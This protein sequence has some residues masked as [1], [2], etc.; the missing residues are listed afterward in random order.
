MTNATNKPKV[1]ISA[2]FLKSFSALPPGQQKKVREFVEKF[3]E[4]PMS[5]GINYEKI[6]QARDPNVRSVRIDQNYR[7]IVLKPETGNAFLLLWVE[8]HDA[9][10]AW[11]KNRIFN[12]HP[13]TGSLQVLDVTADVAIA[14]PV[15]SQAKGL[16]IGFRDKDLFKVG[17]PEILLPLVRS[18][19]T[20][21]Q[22][23][24]A[25]KH[26]PQESSEAL[27]MLASGFS[28][29]EVINERDRK[30]EAPPVDTTDFAAALAA[31]DS[32][33]RFHIVADAG[34]LNEMNAPLEQW[35]I[36]L[37]PSQ[38]KIVELN[39]GGPARVLGGAGTGKTV[40]AMHRA[41]WLAQNFAVG[42]HDRVLLTTF[43][44]NLAEDI[45]ENMR[46][47]CTVD[48]LKK[49][50]IIN[51]DGWV[52]QF[53]RKNGYE[54]KIVFDGAASP[55]WKSALNQAPAG[56]DDSRFLREEW[57]HV[58]QA[59][60]LRSLEDYFRVSRI[61][62][63]RRLSRLDKKAIWPVFEEYRAQLNAGG[64]KELVDATRDARS[65]LERRGDILPYK[66]ILVDE[67]QDMGMEAFRLIRQMIPPARS[68]QQNNIYITGDAHQRIYGHKVVLGH[69]GIDVRG[70]SRKLRINYRTTEETRKWAIRLLEGRPIDDLDGGQDTQKGYRS[71]LHGETPQI[72]HAATFSDE[73]KKI[74]EH[75]A[76]LKTNGTAMDNI[77]LLARTNELLNQ[78]EGAIKAAGYETY[79]IR[80]SVSDDRRAKGLRIAT[81]HR[82]KGLEFD[83]IIIAGVNEGALPLTLQGDNSPDEAAESET[84][85]RAL[86]YVA[87]TRAKRSVLVTSHG[88]KSPFLQ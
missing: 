57:E 67:A 50:E 35:R 72:F 5:P 39:T 52:S 41:R 23:E 9:A 64:F 74:L 6:Q 55:Q 71:L 86:L 69:C 24:E 47:L 48:L 17:I 88:K 32:Q 62:R 84:K 14:P 1:A 49:I 26:L 60:G 83:S 70:R 29:D 37:H 30:A 27:F 11:A 7:G 16:F 20:E 68:D 53:L 38:K 21:T 77:C 36:F 79:R 22:L 63:G 82:V 66:A 8:Q 15:P 61:G 4:N 31:P 65:L 59:H 43:T 45:L 75:L 10:Y 25:C 51:L 80:R 28:L 34:E 46:K 76:T 2:D 73:I 40:V 3:R 85:E 12:I 58:V 18:L 33:L 81:M 44:K 56:H 13:E 19:E 42:E 87:A 78:Y 54:N